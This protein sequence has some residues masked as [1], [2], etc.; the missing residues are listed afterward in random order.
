[1]FGKSTIDSGPGAAPIIER[2]EK[3]RRLVRQD[4]LVVRLSLE[5]QLIQA[6]CFAVVSS[7]PEQIREVAQRIGVPAIQSNRFSVG[8]LGPSQV[9]LDVFQ[10]RTIVTMRVRNKWLLPELGCVILVGRVC[11]VGCHLNQTV[12]PRPELLIE[13]LLHR[14]GH[15]CGEGE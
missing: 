9:L 14:R 15:G 7:L 6:C 2:S 13:Q 8:T 10:E 11:S 12:S 4:I 3:E 5:G 1:M